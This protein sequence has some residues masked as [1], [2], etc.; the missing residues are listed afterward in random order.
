MI[1]FVITLVALLTSSRVMWRGEYL[2]NFS[3]VQRV[4]LSN[5]AVILKTTLR[6]N[7]K[8]HNRL[9]STRYFPFTI[10]LVSK[11]VAGIYPHV[12]L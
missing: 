6:H 12:E 2:W 4:H 8:Y 11:G 7:P 9:F 3:V 5:L 10:L 1:A